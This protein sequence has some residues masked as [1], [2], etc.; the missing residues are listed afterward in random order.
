MSLPQVGS[1][2]AHCRNSQL[3]L[4]PGPSQEYFSYHVPCSYPD[5]LAFPGLQPKGSTEGS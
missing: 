2:P 3:P 5:I 4:D 1:G